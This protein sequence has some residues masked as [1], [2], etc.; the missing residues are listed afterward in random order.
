[1]YGVMDAYHSVTVKVGDRDPYAPPVR[2]KQKP[3]FLLYII[4]TIMYIKKCKWC[5]K[6]IEVEKQCLFALH[7]CNCDSNPN[8]KIRIEKYKTLFSGKEKVERKVIKQKCPKCDKEFEIKITDKEYKRNKYKKFCSN[9]CANSHIVSD[10]L[11]NKISE[12]CKKSE[13]VKIA[14]SVITENRKFVLD[15]F[16]LKRNE[17][18]EFTCLY[19]GEV[20]YDRRNNKDRKYHSECSKKTSGG[21]R[22]GSSRGKSGWYKGYW[23]DSSYE[24]AYL[25]YNLDHNIKIER[26]SK[27]YEYTFNNEKH[28]FYPDFR[29]DNNLVEIKNYRS[30][31]TEIKLKSVDEKIEIYYK[32]TIKPYLE[33][34]KNKYGENFIEMYEKI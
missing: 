6:D 11:K 15:N 24:L 10:E 3:N 14:N 9:K 1:M 13:K 31:L 29:V 26:N 25:I 2:N 8:K 4:K 19:C 23:C 22:K 32:D 17:I 18:I 27:G 28:I 20:G 30:E 33:Y 16:R 12:S 7:V 34:V 5:E 21:I